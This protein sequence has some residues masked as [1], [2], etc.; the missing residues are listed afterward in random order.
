MMKL[1][2]AKSGVVITPEMKAAAQKANELLHSGEGAGNDFLGWVNL[3]S[4]IDAEQIAAIE[5]QAAKLREK[6][7]VV[8]CI[9]IGGSYLGA[10][11]V[12]EAMSN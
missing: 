8:I 7:E 1:D 4:S 2:V 10:K 9:G 11:A 12:I 6:A 5:A 3:P